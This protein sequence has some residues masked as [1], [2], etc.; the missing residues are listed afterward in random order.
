MVSHNVSHSPGSSRDNLL[1]RAISIACIRIAHPGSRYAC[2]DLILEMLTAELWGT[3]M[4]ASAA[5]SQRRL[6]GQHAYERKAAS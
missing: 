4:K 2:L 5:A 3:P 1:A 6:T